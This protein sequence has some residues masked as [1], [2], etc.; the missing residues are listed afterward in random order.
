MNCLG[1]KKSL[2]RQKKTG[3]DSVNK[4]VDSVFIYFIWKSL[5]FSKNK[6]YL[7]RQ[8][9][10]NSMKNKCT[11]LSIVIIRLKCIIYIYIGLGS[12]IRTYLSCLPAFLQ[13]QID[14]RYLHSFIA[15]SEDL[16]RMALKLA[17]PFW[18]DGIIKIGD[19]ECNGIPRW[20]FLVVICGKL[21]SWPHYEGTW[22]CECKVVAIH[23]ISM[24]ERARHTKF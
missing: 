12:R 3:E 11:I 18:L 20:A 15:V 1:I 13:L 4:L 10:K 14:L 21:R 8:H 6:N 9:W 23:E 19:R 16:R 5:L 2:S 22:S 7:F 17:Q 24:Q